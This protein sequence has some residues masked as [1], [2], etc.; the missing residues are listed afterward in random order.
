MAIDLSPEQWPL[1]MGILNVTPDSFSDGGHFNQP[2]AAIERVR[3]MIEE[4]ADM[5]DIG[6]ESTRPGAPA[7]SQED[8]LARVIPVI[9]AIRRD[10]PI[11]ISVDTSKPAVMR[12]AVAAGA[13]LIND[14]RAL[15][16]PGAPEAAAEL[17]VPICLMHMQGQPRTM[18][19]NPHYEDVVEEVLAFLLQRIEACQGVGITPDKVILDPGFGFGKTAGHNLTL[20]RELGR[21][22]ETGY[23]VLV[24]VSRKSL[25]GKLLGERPV[26]ERLAGSLALATLAGWLGAA[27]LRVHDVRETADALAMCRAVQQA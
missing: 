8:E 24:G 13:S 23:P 3:R 12:A 14:V 10:S 9:E 11:P 16:E 27:I 22:V 25:I 17:G 19:A 2:S 21:F 1:I 26:E 4:G 7:V 20:F 15:Q 5:I 6:G 18:Q